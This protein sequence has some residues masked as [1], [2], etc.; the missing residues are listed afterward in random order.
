[1]RPGIGHVADVVGGSTS[2]LPAGADQASNSWESKPSWVAFSLTV[3]WV[4]V[5]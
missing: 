3:R 5:L 2:R 4:R 1:M